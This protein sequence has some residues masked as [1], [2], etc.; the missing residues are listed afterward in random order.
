MSDWL[1][2]LILGIV[3][4]LTEFLPVS[5]TGHLILVNEF[6][7]FAQD[8]A[9][10]DTFNMF[11]QVGAIGSVLIYFWQRLWIV[12]KE[13][14][15][16]KPDTIELWKKT[17]IGVIP[18]L[19][20]GYLFDD[21]IESYLLRPEV[22]AISLIIGGVILLFIEKR[23]TEFSVN[24]FKDLS[25]KK[26]FSIGLIQCLAM[27]PGVSRSASSILGGMALGLNRVVAAEFSFFLAIPTLSAASAYFLLKNAMGFNS[28]Q[29]AIL[30][31]GFLVAFIVAYLV[32]SVFMR[33]IQKNDFVPF[34]VYRIILGSGILLYFYLK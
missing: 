9:F 16:L 17:L 24:E 18:A 6:I 30:G 31:F 27:I 7:S 20:L 1:I 10:I 12:D 4:G 33:Y 13:T 26:A 3:E 21:I 29:F 22:V 25:Y 15:Q 32:I 8:Q 2:A 34:G 14:R 19:I 23:F 5:S 28:Y 11:I